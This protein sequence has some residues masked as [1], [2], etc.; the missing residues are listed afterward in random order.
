MKILISEI[1]YKTRI[2][3]LTRISER[4][5]KTQNLKKIFLFYRQKCILILNYK[6]MQIQ[7]TYLVY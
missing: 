3:E 5:R 7:I 1:L 4:N 6:K 2:Y